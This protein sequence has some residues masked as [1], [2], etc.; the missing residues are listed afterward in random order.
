M[1]LHFCFVQNCQYYEIDHIDGNKDHN[2]IWNLQ[3]VTPQENTYRAI[4]NGQRPASVHSDTNDV[5]SDEQAIELYNRAYMLYDR[6]IY[7]PIEMDELAEEFG[8][9]VEYIDGLVRGSIRPYIADRYY[10]RDHRNDL[11]SSIRNYYA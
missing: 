2:F 7:H 9:T 11:S 8:V 10:G 3:W 4:I 6:P 1:M 5:L